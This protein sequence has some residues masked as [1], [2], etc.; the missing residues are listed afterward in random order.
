MVDAGM[1]LVPEGWLFQLARAGWSKD[2]YTNWGFD[3]FSFSEPRVPE[4]SIR[5]L[6]KV[7]SVVH[8][9]EWKA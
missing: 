6:R 4:G 9:S 5:Y 2:T 3:Q 1:K 8:D 7:Y